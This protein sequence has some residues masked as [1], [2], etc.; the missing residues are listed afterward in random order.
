MGPHNRDRRRKKI[1]STGLHLKV[2][3]RQ[4]DF[5]HEESQLDR[6][7]KNTGTIIVKL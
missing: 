5:G 3:M 2:G 6:S 4:C 1:N 7:L